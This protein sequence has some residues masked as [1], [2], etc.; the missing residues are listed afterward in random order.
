MVIHLALIRRILDLLAIGHGALR[1]DVHFAPED[2]LD[3]VL[4][5][6]IVK[7]VGA[8]HDTMIGKGN[9]RHTVIFGSRYEILDAAGTIKQGIVRVIV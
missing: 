4:L 8:E 9:G 1:D 7:F 5:R 2:R 6:L 3:P